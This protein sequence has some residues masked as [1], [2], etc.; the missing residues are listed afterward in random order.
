MIDQQRFDQAD[1]VV[2]GVIDPSNP[3]FQKIEKSRLDRIKKW[4]PGCV[5]HRQYFEYPLWAIYGN[6]MVE[7]SIHKGNVKDL[8]KHTKVVW[9]YK[10]PYILPGA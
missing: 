6:V 2:I 5:P 4:N 10:K 3:D 7:G 9:G 8:R 1:M